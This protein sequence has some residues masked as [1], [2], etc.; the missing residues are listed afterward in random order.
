MRK[1]RAYLILGKKTRYIYGAFPRTK[2]GH[3]QAK[4]YKKKLS[5]KQK[6][7]EFIIK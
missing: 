5:K 6:G 4:D 3:A 1:K 7:L 2:E